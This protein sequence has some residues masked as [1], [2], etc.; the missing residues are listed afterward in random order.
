MNGR[1]AVQI[2]ASRFSI[3]IAEKKN[4]K[5]AIRVLRGRAT[6]TKRSFFTATP[7]RVSGA[8]PRGHL[9]PGVPEE[10]GGTRFDS[11]RGVFLFRKRRRAIVFSF[12]RDYSLFLF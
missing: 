9:S 5:R 4:T 10:R 3:E 2:R 11:A 12:S 6:R 8:G 1:R 7:S